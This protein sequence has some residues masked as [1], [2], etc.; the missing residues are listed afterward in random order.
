MDMMDN[1]FYHAGQKDGSIT[2]AESE[3]LAG[4]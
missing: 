1:A 4:A 2:L 3:V